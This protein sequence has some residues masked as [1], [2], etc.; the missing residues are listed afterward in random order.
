MKIIGS[1]L[2]FERI[3][4]ITKR[5]K[6]NKKTTG[7]M[8]KYIMVGYVRNHTRDIYKMYNTETKRVIMTRC[9]KWADWK[10]TDPS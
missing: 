2:E 8:Y 6:L 7:K 3:F 1:L 9:I 5:N 4:Y 10:M